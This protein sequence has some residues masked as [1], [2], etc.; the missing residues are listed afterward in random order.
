ML[1]PEQIQSIAAQRGDTI[2]NQPTSSDTPTAPGMDPKSIQDRLAQFDELVGPP[3]PATGLRPA[4]DAVVSTVKKVGGGIMD[5][6]KSAADK[7]IEQQ[8]QGG[9][10]MVQSVTEG[11]DKLQK[12]ENQDVVHEGL[13]NVETGLGTASGAVQAIFAPITGIIQAISEKASDS[14]HVQ[15]F[16]NGV[17]PLVDLYGQLES[18]VEEISK[19][20]P[21]AAKNIGDAAN[22]LLATMG[23]ET[24]AAKTDVGAGQQAIVK[25]AGDA[26][27]ALT[28]KPGDP[29][30]SSSAP[31][32]EPAPKTESGAPVVDKTQVAKEIGGSM[33]DTALQQIFGM[34]LDTINF[35]KENPHFS[36]PE[37]LRAADIEKISKEAE[38]AYGEKAKTVPNRTQVAEE[39]Q[40][41]VHAQRPDIPTVGEINSN[42]EQGLQKKVHALNE[43]AKEYSTLGNDSAPGAPRKVIKVEPNWLRTQIQKIAGAKIGDAGGPQAGKITHIDAMSPVSQSR[44]FQAGGKLQ[45]L[46]DDWAPKFATGKMSRSEFLNF[47]QTL[48][49]IANYKGGVDTGLEKVAHGI[50][51]NLNKTYRPQIPNLEKIDI[52]HARLNKDLDESLAGIATI[53]KTG[54]VPKI[55]MNEGSVS[56]MMNADKATRAAMAARLENIV[57]GT[58][59]KIEKMNN[60]NKEW[61]NIFDEHGNMTEGAINKMA[62]ATAPGKDVLLAKLE[63]T[64]PGIGAKIEQMKQFEKDW[65][66]IFDQ[67]GR[68]LDDA[69]GKIQNAI[70]EGRQ[71]RLE[72]LKSLVPDIE[73]KLD[74]LKAKHDIFGSALKPGLYTKSGLLSSGMTATAMGGGAVGIPVMLASLASQSP[75]VMLKILQ[76]LG[77][78]S[79]K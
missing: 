57:P 64:V 56:N 78:V 13:T 62:A 26:K 36:T 66:G 76:T 20:H 17:G 1:S 25:A 21:E 10:K 46:W 37:V 68:L 43:H 49:E 69:R 60:F 30:V 38:Q 34:P 22:V 53:D 33:R 75:T 50:R 40:N 47:R 6:A 52:E 18:K 77:K 79:K 58:V 3:K 11:A 2:V 32:F 27:E 16:A 12:Q 14:K 67:H 44:S 54:I 45:A 65:Q 15:D 7:T 23:G 74:L 70:N 73:T 59:A 29:T 63:K 51:D 61:G 42:I 39:V 9:K 19:A 72:R 31:A 71:P 28:P 35:L 4:T 5:I 24:G 55:K 8:Q 41:A 48:A